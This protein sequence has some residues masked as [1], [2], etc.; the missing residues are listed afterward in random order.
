LNG[1]PDDAIGNATVNVGEVHPIL[2]VGITGSTY[3]VAIISD[4]FFA[5]ESCADLRPSHCVIV[6]T[7]NAGC[8]SLGSAA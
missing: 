7:A 5:T 3:T 8:I 1:D 6:I 4:D 2:I